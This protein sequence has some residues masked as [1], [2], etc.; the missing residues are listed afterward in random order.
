MVRAID[1]LRAARPTV[2]RSG[3]QPIAAAAVTILADFAARERHEGATATAMQSMARWLPLLGKAAAAEEGS[4]A[5]AAAAGAW[6]AGLASKLAANAVPYAFSVVEA[7]IA[8]PAIRPAFAAAGIGRALFDVVSVV[9]VVVVGGRG[10][11]W[12]ARQHL[13]SRS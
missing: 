10:W 11:W 1:A 6:A 5:V 7:L 13:L 4:E 2:G 3:C 9:V 8:C 12:V